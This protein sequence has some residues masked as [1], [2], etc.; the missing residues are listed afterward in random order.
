MTKRLTL[1]LLFLIVSAGSAFSQVVDAFQVDTTEFPTDTLLLEAIVVTPKV[2]NT[3]GNKESIELSEEARKIG[4][5][6]LDA[7]GSLPQFKTNASNGDLI[8]VD[9]KSILV[10]IDGI[11]RSTRELM[12]LRSEDVKRYNFTAILRQDML[13]R[14][15]ELSLT[16]LPEKRRTGYIAFILIQRMASL[17]VMGLICFHWHIWTL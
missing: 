17:P 6:A 8:T 9:N 2:L 4:N 16:L 7:I 3:F 1:S 5:N 12:L 11:R 15:S 14:I 10:L 13:T